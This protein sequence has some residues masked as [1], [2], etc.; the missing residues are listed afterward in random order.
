VLAVLAVTGEYASGTIRATL[1]AVPR[2]PLVVAAKCLVVGAACLAAAEVLAF[3]CFFLGQAVLAGIGDPT[4]SLGGHRVAAAV[5]LSGAFLA[6]LAVGAMALGLMV[7]NSAGAIST[8]VGLV[9]LLPV[10]LQ[11]LPGHP[12][13]FTPL[14]LLANSVS[15][16]V[17]GG[18][19]VSLPVAFALL[20]AYVVTVLAAA[21]ALFFRRDA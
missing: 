10:V 8:Y 14:L 21:A 4:A 1:S 11:R 17:P 15:A 7:R 9:F 18:E 19:Q 2:R 20:A 13:R 3:G 16:T 5:V 12:A 6:I